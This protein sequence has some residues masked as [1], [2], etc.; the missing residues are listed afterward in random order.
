MKLEQ[1]GKILFKESVDRIPDLK[2]IKNK[3]L[4]DL[5][6]LTGS[7]VRGNSDAS[8]DIDLFF[9]V[10]LATEKKYKLKPEYSFNYIIN[11]KDT[12][13]EISFVTTEK[14]INDQITKNHIFWWY[15]S[16]PVYYKNKSILN[17]LQKASNYS[18]EEYL[19]KLWTLNFMF[20]LGI[21]E[22]EKNTKRFGENN[23][24]ASIIY[25]DCI[26]NFTEFYLLTKR[27]I[28]RFNS[29]EQELNKI[30]KS[31]FDNQNFMIIDLSARKKI[32]ENCN[33]KI[34]ELLL[35]NKFKKAQIEN[36][37]SFGLTHL[38]FQKY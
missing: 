32:L 15:K 6:V 24:T 10:P 23:L 21:Y 36:W 20:K 17:I 26:R 5:V 7:V 30:D 37:S 13:I 2:R 16:I 14:L 35:A 18:K 3:N 33:S 1:I 8:S 9:V 19:D 22:F 34:D 4:V 29:F 38:N 25:F 11:K 27:K 28:I 31:F 12:K